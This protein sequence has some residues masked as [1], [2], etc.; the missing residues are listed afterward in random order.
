MAIQD[1]SVNVFT[2][3]S[4]EMTPRGLSRTVQV[5]VSNDA[6]NGGRKAAVFVAAL[7]QQ[8]QPPGRQGIIT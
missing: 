6:E 5:I 7:Y 2:A 1:L 4:S 8:V 3:P